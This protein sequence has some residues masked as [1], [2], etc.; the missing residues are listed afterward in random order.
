MKR[1]DLP[2]RFQ[3]LLRRIPYVTI[4]TVCPDGSPW[5]SPVVGKFDANMNLYWVSWKDS[6]HS[7]NIACDPRAFVVSYDSQVPEGQGEG[8]YLQM[9]VHELA[10]GELR[11]A[12]KIYDP[13]FFRH[14]FRHGQFLGQCPQRIYKAVPKHI[15]Y[16]IDSEEQ[17]H[18]VDKRTELM[19]KACTRNLD[20]RIQR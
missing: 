16:N 1:T 20:E 18:F 6:Q 10:A 4:A 15:W 5:N 12:R 17:G 9:E 8:L 11:D 7:K 2:N 13:T 3:E 14:E 19:A